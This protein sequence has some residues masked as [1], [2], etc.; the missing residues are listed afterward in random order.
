MN[1]SQEMDGM[2]VYK[3]GERAAKWEMAVLCFYSSKRATTGLQDAIFQ[4][5]L[6][7]QNQASQNLSFTNPNPW[8]LF[9]LKPK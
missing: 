4:L 5:W 1:L 7:R 2:V 9:E 8:V 3:P 6:W